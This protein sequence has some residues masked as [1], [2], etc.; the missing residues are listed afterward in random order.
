MQKLKI[1]NKERLNGETE[2]YSARYFAKVQG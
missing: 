2:T 1:E